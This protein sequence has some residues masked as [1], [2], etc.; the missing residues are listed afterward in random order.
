MRACCDGA[1]TAHFASLMR[2]TSQM[3]SSPRR[4][5]SGVLASR[6]PR[7]ERSAEIG[8]AR[9]RGEPGVGRKPDPA[10][11]AR[12]CLRVPCDR[13]PR[14]SRRSTTAIFR[15]GR[16]S[17]ARAFAPEPASSRSDQRTVVV[18]PVV[19]SR[20]RPGA[21]GA[22][23]RPAGAASCS[24]AAAPG[25]APSRAGMRRLCA[26]ASRGQEEFP[27]FRNHRS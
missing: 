13:D 17:G 4:F 15:S 9:L 6:L 19:G 11:C 2:L 20:L 23:P 18:P 7:G 10:A 3:T 16:S 25:D 5:A 8:A 22:R 26:W 1:P 27:L 24:A 12:R 14:A 21:R